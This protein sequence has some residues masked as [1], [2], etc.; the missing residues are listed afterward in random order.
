MERVLIN[1][2]GFSSYGFV[3]SSVKRAYDFGYKNESVVW[4]IDDT[5]LNFSIG[6]EP[7]SK[8][9]YLER[10]Y[11][12]NQVTCFN[13]E[14]MLW[15]SVEHEDRGPYNRAGDWINLIAAIITSKSI[16]HFSE[17]TVYFNCRHSSQR[18]MILLSWYYT[19][20]GETTMNYAKNVVIFINMHIFFIRNTWLS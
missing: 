9:L 2:I 6:I 16:M 13:V 14:E 11:E 20:R 8:P 15:K 7:I 18:A 4:K 19:A 1:N 5:D 3:Y 10:R 17:K 12:V